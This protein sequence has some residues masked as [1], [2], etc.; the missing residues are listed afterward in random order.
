MST[1]AVSEN[2][3]LALLHKIDFA[4]LLTWGSIPSPVCS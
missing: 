3:R 1:V 2:K 4:A